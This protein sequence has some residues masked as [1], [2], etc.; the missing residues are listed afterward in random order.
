[1]N[2]AQAQNNFLFIFT[3]K[4]GNRTRTTKVLLSFGNHLEGVK[5]KYDEKWGIKT[6]FDGRMKFFI[7]VLSGRIDIGFLSEFKSDIKPADIDSKYKYR[8]NEP[9]V[10]LKEIDEELQLS[11]ALASLNKTTAREI[12]SELMNKLAEGFDEKSPVAVMPRR[13]F[14]LVSEI[15]SD[16]EFRVK[17][18]V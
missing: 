9:E 13:L 1:M 3:N 5:V 6:V 16:R 12:V 10:D 18:R 14:S 17:V 11:E 7:S 8:L 2:T 4:K 15:A